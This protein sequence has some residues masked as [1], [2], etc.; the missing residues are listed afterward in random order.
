MATFTHAGAIL[1]R[2]DRTEPTR[3]QVE[4]AEGFLK[5]IDKGEF[6]KMDTMTDAEL[7]KVT[8]EASFACSGLRDD[9]GFLG[10]YAAINNVFMTANKLLEGRQRRRSEGL[11]DQRARQDTICSFASEAR[12]LCKHLAAVAFDE[13]IMSPC[14]M[15][16]I[17]PEEAQAAEPGDLA[18]I[19]Y[20]AKRGALSHKM[21]LMKLTEAISALEMLSAS[22]HID[23]ALHDLNVRRGYLSEAIEAE[24][25]TV[26]TAN[27]EM[28]RRMREAAEHK[29]AEK[30]LPATVEKLTARIAE[31]EKAAQE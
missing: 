8:R 3:E 13:D 18:R 1:D 20:D 22:G 24:T 4:F 28:Q 5:R 26:D 27:A 17:S 15:P 9:S 7:M 19:A 12:G 31:L 10:R 25:R 30:D 29:K 2:D 14:T 11:L 16:P 23:H 6:K 21:E